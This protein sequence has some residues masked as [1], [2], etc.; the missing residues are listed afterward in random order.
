MFGTG[1]VKEK[2]MGLITSLQIDEFGTVGRTQDGQILRST[3]RPPFSF[4]YEVLTYTPND[5]SIFWKLE[6]H[7]L[8]EEQQAEVERQID[9][10]SID[11]ELTTQMAQNHQA[12]KILANT[13]WYV[14]RK[15]E[16]GKEIPDDIIDMRNKARSLVIHE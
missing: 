2:D 6:R 13:D 9:T 16:T 8:T 11:T 5:K 10:I 3:S 14:I 7:L 4:D 15:M 1:S 12:R